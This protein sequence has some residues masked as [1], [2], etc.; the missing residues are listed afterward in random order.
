M[1]GK[2]NVTRAAAVVAAAMLVLTGCS[3]TT[4]GTYDDGSN[5]SGNE[6]IAGSLSE[7][8]RQAL[9]NPRNAENAF[10]VEVL[11]R[12]IDTGSIAQEDYDEAHRLYRVCMNDA[13]YD[14]SYTQLANGSYQITPP[15]LEGQDAVE[16][17]MDVGTE[18]AAELA[19]IE[20][21]F[22]TQQGNPDLLSDPS[23][24]AVQCLIEAGIVD[25]SYT[26]QK[27]REDLDTAFQSA[28]YDPMSSGAQTCF[29]N[30]GFSVS[31]GN[32]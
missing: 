3:S 4:E 29:S 22:I 28:S 12:A 9:D 26:P 19:P 18:C 17:Y 13:G 14:E 11:N 6:K 2:K 21:L 16:K 31:I 32:E 25:A 10:V 24:V 1:H 20:A 30:A 27:L 23:Q 15:S 8:F 5:S 7:L